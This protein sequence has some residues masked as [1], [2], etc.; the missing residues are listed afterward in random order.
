M[1]HA[2]RVS[3]KKLSKILRDN[4]SIFPH[5]VAIC[6]YGEWFRPTRAS[7]PNL[8]GGR[9]GQ[10]GVPLHV[11]AAEAESVSLSRA[12]TRSRAFVTLCWNDD[13]E[14]AS[15]CRPILVAQMITLS[16]RAHATKVKPVLIPHQ[17]SFAC[18]TAWV[19]VCA[20][21]L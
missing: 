2:Q 9:C 17:F 19:R 20:S 13:N 7:V 12:G 3:L 15:E 11:Y 8:G 21:D 4:E 16:A 10:S 18:S 14:K 5:V 1:A 6:T